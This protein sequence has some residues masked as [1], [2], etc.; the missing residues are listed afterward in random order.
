MAGVEEGAATAAAPRQRSTA[1]RLVRRTLGNAWDD[2]VF[3]ESAAAAFWQTLSLPPLLLGLFGV[4]SYVG[5]LYGP[6]TV[7]AVQASIVDV[8]GRIFTRDALDQIVAPTVSSVLTTARADVVSLGFLISFWSG[9]SAMASFV[10]AIT[11]AHGQY[12]L[13][14]LVWQRVLAILVYL[15]SL[16]TG[17][18]LLPVLALGPDRLA[19]LLPAGW[20]HTGDLVLAGLYYPIIGLTLVVALTTL[21]KIALPLK[22]PWHRGLPGALLA[23]VVF[24]LGVTGLR[25]YLDWV[26][27]TGYT[28][29]ALAAPIAFLLATFFIGFSIILGA[30]L[31]AAVQALWPVSLRDRRGRCADEDRAGSVEPHPP[32]DVAHAVRHDPEAA[33]AVLETLD[34]VVTRPVPVGSGR[35]PGPRG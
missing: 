7:Q 4:L 11:R 23:A 28:Y 14:N 35:D 5:G 16:A 3:S 29:G 22:P 15:V 13:R 6:D 34:Y 19:H 24:L 12:Q 8:T 30:H 26:T 17:V 20:Q 31:N 10:D 21:Y 33:A 9:S 2:D 32:V 27:S 25:T 1:Q 18:L